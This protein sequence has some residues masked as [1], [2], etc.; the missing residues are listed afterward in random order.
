MEKIEP[1]YRHSYP[2]KCTFLGT[3][4]VGHHI[5]DLYHVKSHEGVLL[6]V[7]YGNGALQLYAEPVKY[8]ELEKGNNWSFVGEAYRRATKKELPLI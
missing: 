3:F 6:L 7:R 8:A 4:Q 1:K 5:N 2:S